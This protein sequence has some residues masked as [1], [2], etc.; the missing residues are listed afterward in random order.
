MKVACSLAKPEASRIGIASMHYA[1]SVSA[2]KDSLITFEIRNIRFIGTR[3]AHSRIA[4][5]ISIDSKMKIY[6]FDIRGNQTD[7]FGNAFPKLKMTG[8]QS[9]TDKAQA[10]AMWKVYVQKAYL[11]SLPP[12]QYQQALRNIFKHK[13]P[14]VLEK[15]ALALM[16]L[17]ISFKGGV[18][19]DPENI[20]GSIADA[21]FYNDKNLYGSFLPL[22]GET[23]G[24]V[25]CI[26][27]VSE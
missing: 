4:S 23:A 27:T 19:G 11:D 5:P 10:Y 24:R 20:F 26:I 17:K 22:K 16:D 15:D 18:H 6:S 21:L 9:W 25:H 8:K 1:A 3:P 2:R 14:I 12:D 13:K 7:P